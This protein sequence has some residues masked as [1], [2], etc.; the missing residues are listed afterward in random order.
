MSELVKAASWADPASGARPRDASDCAN[1]IEQVETASW[2]AKASGA[3]PRDA[4][5]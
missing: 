5:D 3:R 1:F 2:S 4:N